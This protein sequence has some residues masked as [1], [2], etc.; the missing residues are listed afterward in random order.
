MKTPS[1]RFVCSAVAPHQYPTNGL[2]E[3]VFFGRSNVGKSSLINSLLRVS[4]L[5]RT[6]ATPG[7]TQHINFFRIDEAFYFVDLPGY[8]YARAPEEVR[9]GWAAMI[10]TYLNDRPQIAL[11]VLI[12]DARLD[13]TPLDRQMH[14][15]MGAGQLA[16]CVAATKADKLSNN[17]L[18]TSLAVL[19][20]AYGPH[21]I[22]YSSVTGK[23]REEIW[24]VIRDLT[25]TKGNT[26]KK[27]RTAGGQAD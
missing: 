26:R 21:V 13:P 25:G 4:G 23:G 16:C 14:D 1:A 24:R 19:K 5:A 6:S 9:E 22:P 8:G 12:V 27:D 15:W 20:R 7:R 11:G 17:R 10:E 3:V 2:P 18:T